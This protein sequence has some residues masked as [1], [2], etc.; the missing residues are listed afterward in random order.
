MFDSSQPYCK[1]IPQ[2][3]IDALVRYGEKGI[4]PGDFLMAVLSDNF[5][6]SVFRADDRNRLILYEIS[7][8]IHNEIP[9]TSWG[10]VEKVQKWIARG[11]LEGLKEVT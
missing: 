5:S 1:V 8:F 9:D 11:G 10:S 3:I 6:Q 7:I 4:P 2:L